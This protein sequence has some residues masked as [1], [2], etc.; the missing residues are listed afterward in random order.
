[1]YQLF[2][3]LSHSTIGPA[4][5]DFLADRGRFLSGAPF[6]TPDAT[7]LIKLRHHLTFRGRYKARKSHKKKN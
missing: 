2:L 5:K 3:F 1:M 7:I 6:N 4:T